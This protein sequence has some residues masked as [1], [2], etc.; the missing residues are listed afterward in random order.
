MNDYPVKESG[1]KRAELQV[2]TEVSRFQGL[3]KKTH[4]AV[5]EL[6][7]RL[8]SVLRSLPPTTGGSGGEPSVPKVGLASV[9]AAEN[10]SLGY[11]AAK[12]KSILD[13]L[14]I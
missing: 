4:E 1:S 2:V 12:V 9:L 8:E 13:R 11:I 5:T 14:E 7:S 10:D 3:T 6:E